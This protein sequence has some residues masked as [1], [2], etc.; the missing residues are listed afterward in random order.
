MLW[1]SV[2]AAVLQA[3]NELLAHGIAAASER[4]ESRPAATAPLHVQSMLAPA[5]A[6]HTPE[7]SAEAGPNS[8][9]SQSEDEGVFEQRPC[10]SDASTGENAAGPAGAGKGAN[11]ELAK[12]KLKRLQEAYNRRGVLAGSSAK[13]QTPPRSLELHWKNAGCL[14]LSPLL[15][16]RPGL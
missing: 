12:K 3:N 10:G 5:A 8:S 7:Q 9:P 14:C 16:E 11:R 6:L 2:L 1:R 13:E 4:T 15:Q